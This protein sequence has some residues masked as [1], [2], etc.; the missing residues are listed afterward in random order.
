M[1]ALI[2]VE[3]FPF[4]FANLFL[5]FFGHLPDFHGLVHPDQIASLEY[6]S[7]FFPPGFPF[8]FVFDPEHLGSGLFVSAIP[9]SLR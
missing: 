3:D 1:F 6:G 7:N 8:F 9:G 4:D 2:L 5:M